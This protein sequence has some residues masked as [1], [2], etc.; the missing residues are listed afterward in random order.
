MCGLQKRVAENVRLA[1]T[2][3]GFTQKHLA[4]LTRLS[5][6]SIREIETGRRFP[7][8]QSIDRLAAAL[9]LKPYKLLYDKEQM[10]LYDKYERIA[11]YYCELNEKINTILDDTT[12]KYLKAAGVL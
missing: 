12:T 7:T 6:S 3:L 9:G 4:D 1:R 5:L 8:A 2:R 11:N 10:E